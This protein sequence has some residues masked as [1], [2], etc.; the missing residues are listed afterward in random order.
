MADTRGLKHILANTGSF[1][2]QKNLHRIKWAPTCITLHWEPLIALAIHHSLMKGWWILWFSNWPSVVNWMGVIRSQ[3]WGWSE[4]DQPRRLLFGSWAELSLLMVKVGLPLEAAKVCW[5]KSFL[6]TICDALL[7][8]LTL[9]LKLVLN[10]RVT[11]LC[12]LATSHV[13]LAF[14][15][16]HSSNNLCFHQ[17]ISFVI[18][19][20]L[21]QT[22]P[23][24][25][26][27]MKPCLYEFSVHINQHPWWSSVA[28]PSIGKAPAGHGQPFINQHLW[29]FA[30]TL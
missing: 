28:F 21:M 7:A 6:T 14:G 3:P 18:V 11:C 20:V 15:Q 22:I 17:P 19:H 23:H 12:A 1:P 5:G 9:C 4:L 2:W 13:T 30:N 8:V 27:N 16:N 10:Q 25:N 29:T 26:A 24:A